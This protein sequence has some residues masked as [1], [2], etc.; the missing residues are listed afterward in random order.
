MKLVMNPVI[1]Y[2]PFEEALKYLS[3]LGVECIEIGAGGYPG[4]AHL[5]P[6]E[7]LGNDEK[8]NEYKSLLKKYNME[9]S[10]ISC[11]GNALHPNKETAAKFDKEFRN[12]ILVAEALGV[13]TVIGF[14]GCPGDC[15]ESKNPN[16]A[17]FQVPLFN[18]SHKLRSNLLKHC[19][20]SDT[21]CSRIINGP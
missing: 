15:E 9:I 10:A 18:A 19:F 5:K 13:D 17:D 8:I 16:W 21:P 7:V 2:M 20:Y 4:D 1:N 14:S 11:H 12:A 3:G 6:E